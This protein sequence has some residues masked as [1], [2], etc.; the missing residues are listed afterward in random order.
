MVYVATPWVKLLSETSGQ[1][2]KILGAIQGSTLSHQEKVT[3]HGS[4]LDE[5][6]GGI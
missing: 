2:N 1:K 6:I 5:P 3:V 4:T